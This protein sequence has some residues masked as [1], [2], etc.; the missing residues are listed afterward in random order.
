MIQK[1]K[2]IIPNSYNKKT[3]KILFFLVISMLFEALGLGLLLPIVTIILDPEV[4]NNY[5]SF[6]RFLFEYGIISHKQI[7]SFVMIVFGFLYFIKSF[8]LVYVSWVIADYSQGLSNYL[9][10]KLFAGYIRQNY[11]VS[12]NTNSANLQRNVTNEV[13]QF[14]A[15]VTNLL[16]LV[17]EVAICISILVT[18]LYVDPFGAITV[19]GV[20]ILLSLVY[21]FSS[22]GYIYKLGIKRFQFDQKR[23]FTLIQSL[24][25]FKEIK[26]FNKESFFISVFKLIKTFD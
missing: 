11:I 18:L 1:I 15:F 8:F 7:I 3:I 9:S 16:F 23:I 26:L 2:S 21:Y 4:L 5:P 17:S 25:S 6:T 12:I 13:L 20:L 10:S 24:G 19:M 22:K 14:T